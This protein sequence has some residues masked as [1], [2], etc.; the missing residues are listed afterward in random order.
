VKQ[1][2][3][4]FLTFLVGLGFLLSDRVWAEE[5]RPVGG[6]VSP[7]IEILIDGKKYNTIHEYKLQKIKIVLQKAL[8][9]YNLQG[10]SEDELIQVVKEVRAQ[11][12]E[13]YSFQKMSEPAR[14][15][16]ENPSLDDQ[17]VAE[18]VS[19]VTVLEMREMLQDYLK[20]HDASKPLTVDFNKLKTII[21]KP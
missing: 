2:R 9:A 6:S 21:I 18:D 3:N 4:G 13:N 5:T 7:G 10:F 14:K 17:T 1:A 12:L 16:L 15:N 11:Q 8:A 20:E 19:D